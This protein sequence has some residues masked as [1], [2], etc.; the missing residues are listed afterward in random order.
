MRWVDGNGSSWLLLGLIVLSCF[1][2]FFFA[3]PRFE[4]S[5]FVRARSPLSER[6]AARSRA[7]A[8]ALT[9]L[10]SR[11]MLNGVSGSSKY[12]YYV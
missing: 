2:F 6:T 5:C 1:A 9:A 3:E 10:A 7:R 4:W 12:I 11:V 8:S